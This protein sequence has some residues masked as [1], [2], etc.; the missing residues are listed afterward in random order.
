MAANQGS[1][2]VK[3]C[4]GQTLLVEAL[5][6]S[7]WGDGG[8]L[9]ISLSLWQ[10]LARHCCRTTQPPFQ[11]LLSNPHSSTSFSKSFLILYLY[12]SSSLLFRRQTS[13]Y[14]REL[15]RS[16][17]GG[18]VGLAGMNTPSHDQLLHTQTL[19][20]QFWDVTCGIAGWHFQYFGT[21]FPYIVK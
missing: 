13:N 12:K 17:V 21:F 18:W 2:R 7:Q 6:S 11:H 5:S 8:G 9:E 4:R 14:E 10:L 19:Q 1:T 20:D 16:V 3:Y 15:V